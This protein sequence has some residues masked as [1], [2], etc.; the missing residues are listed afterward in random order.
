ML[1]ENFF[2]LFCKPKFIKTNIVT[3][4]KNITIL[5]LDVE[6]GKD[7]LIAQK[8]SFSEPEYIC[9]PGSIPRNN[10]CGK[11]HFKEF[12]SNY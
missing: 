12:F 9:Q 2:Q 11:I 3:Y 7:L 8:L 1:H 6:I 5:V 10:T 4:K